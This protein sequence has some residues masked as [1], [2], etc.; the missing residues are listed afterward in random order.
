MQ[1]CSRTTKNPG[2]LRITSSWA[3]W[4]EKQLLSFVNIKNDS[5]NVNFTFCCW[6]KVV[7]FDTETKKNKELKHIIHI[8]CTI[9]CY[10]VYV[11]PQVT[12]TINVS[13]WDV[14]F[15]SDNLYDVWVYSKE[16]VLHN[17]LWHC[18]LD[19]GIKKQCR[20]SCHTVILSLILQ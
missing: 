11:L 3:E 17:I 6:R 13:I 15:Y 4:N 14:F 5:T 2:L 12:Q 8:T 7:T 10:N 19:F 20:L 16:R 1:R 9:N 18:S